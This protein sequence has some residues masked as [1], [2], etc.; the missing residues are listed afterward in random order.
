MWCYTEISTLWKSNLQSFQRKFE[1]HCCRLSGEV[2]DTVVHRRSSSRSFYVELQEVPELD[3]WDSGSPR[4]P[5]GFCSGTLG[6]TASLEPWEYSHLDW[7]S[8][9][10]TVFAFRVRQTREI[11][12]VPV[13]SRGTV[14]W[15]LRFWTSVYSPVEWRQSCL[16]LEAGATF[17]L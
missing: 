12:A 6:S 4:S 9:A 2:E 13:T 3:T 16:F 7:L 1:E 17:L 8:M 10:L 14:S 15:F 5:V 11:L